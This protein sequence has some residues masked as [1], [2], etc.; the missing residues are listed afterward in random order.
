MRS[1]KASVGWALILGVLVIAGR[2]AAAQ[3]PSPALLVVNKEGNLAIV[4]PKS[5]KVMGRVPTGDGPHEV[6]V[7][8]DGRL[9]F[10]SNYGA[11]TP[12]SSISVIDIVEQKEIR[13]IE[14]GALS[15]PHG[16]TFAGG[17]LYF[18]A[19]GFKMI[20][21]Y[22]PVADKIDW[23]M[24]TGQNRTHMVILTKD[25]NQIFTSNIGSNTVTAM[26]RSFDPPDWNETVI[27]VGKGPEGIDLSPDGKEVW[28]AH[29]ADGGVSIIDVATGK[30]K[31]TL[32][33]HTKRS[34]RLVFTP[35]GKM[36]LVSDL[37]TGELVVLDAPSRKEIKRIKLGAGCAGTLVAPDGSRAYVA[38]T[39]DNNVAV[40]DLK[41][42]EVVAR[43][44]TGVS[45]DGMAWA[46]RK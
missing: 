15:Q 17:K 13:R 11:K 2:F 28:T 6:A 14:I 45:P 46:E 35:D 10:V 8:D 3:M 1:K 38:V 34:N 32:D 43:L 33:L 19:Q 41:K 5:G 25:L 22:D 16:V 39:P 9:A 44:S 42:W 29:G 37:G 30:V 24:G 4:D 27:P 18:T 26:E 23:M 40:I 21:R 31:E 12:G 20:G 36:V 7:S